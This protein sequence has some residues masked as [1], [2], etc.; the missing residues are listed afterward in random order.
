M[1]PRWCA[2]RIYRAWGIE[3][4]YKKKLQNEAISFYPPRLI[5]VQSYSL[6]FHRSS[7]LSP[8]HTFSTLT[9]CLFSSLQQALDGFCIPQSAMALQ[10][11]PS[12]TSQVPAYEPQNPR[13][14]S[15]S[16]IHQNPPHPE[17]AYLPRSQRGDELRTC[18]TVS[19]SNISTTSGLNPS[20]ITRVTTVTDHTGA[21]T[22]TTVD[23]LTVC[24]GSHL[25][26]Q[27]LI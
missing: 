25:F 11:F 3:F 13:V 19:I 9:L 7:L 1:S 24:A 23:D 15:S 2:M 10:Y 20:K 27:Q 26:A 17:P 21:I 6:T 22:E 14:P 16:S 18:A 5:P 12:N 8:V 4:I